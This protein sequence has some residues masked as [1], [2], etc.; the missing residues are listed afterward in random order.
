V[1]QSHRCPVGAFFTR[2]YRIMSARYLEE[3]TDADTAASGSLLDEIRPL[4]A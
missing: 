3:S 1:Q 4:N 2:S